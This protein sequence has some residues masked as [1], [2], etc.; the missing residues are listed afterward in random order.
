[1]L[2]HLGLAYLSAFPQIVNEIGVAGSDCIATVFH[3]HFLIVDEDGHTGG[4]IYFTPAI[5]HILIPLLN[6]SHGGILLLLEPQFQEVFYLLG[7]RCI[8][9]FACIEGQLG[10]SL[11]DIR[12]FLVGF[13]MTNKE[14]VIAVEMSNQIF[15]GLIY[16]ALGITGTGAYL[17]AIHIVDALFNSRGQF[18]QHTL[19]Q[20]GCIGLLNGND[21]HGIG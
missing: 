15:K 16:L 3:G 7:S 5:G 9:L 18:L 21:A 8:F 11:E 2:L 13:H 19:F 12:D 14:I 4:N 6:V 17:F 20:L 10:S 1:M